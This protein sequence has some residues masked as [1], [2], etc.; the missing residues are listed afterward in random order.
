M[1]NTNLLKKIL[2]C[3]FIIF[4]AVVL[5]L[6][7]HPPNF[8]PIAGLAL[9]SGANL[10]KKQAF[11]IL[12]ISMLV[13][14]LFLGFHSTM[15][16]VYLSFMLII[17]IGVFLKR[18]Q[19]FTN[20]L[21]ASLTSSVLFYVITNFG[22]WMSTSMYPKNIYGLIQSYV[23]AIPFF[24]NTVL[25]DFFYTFSFFYGYKYSLLFFNQRLLMIFKNR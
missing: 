18:N 20:I 19:V 11:L 17:Y 6:L 5:R 21:I 13:S 7:P 24:K 2:A 14:D 12:F 4:L 23:F 1:E 3:F 25:S 9:F 15:P 8:A 22:V 16:Y 10:S